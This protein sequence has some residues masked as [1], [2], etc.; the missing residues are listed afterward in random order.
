M[1]VF[2]RVCVSE[3]IVVLRAPV[4]SY[5]PFK[6]KQWQ[7][8]FLVLVLYPWRLSRTATPCP[9]FPE[10][11]VPLNALPVN[12]VTLPNCNQSVLKEHDSPRF[13][14]RV[15]PSQ[16]VW[17][18]HVSEIRLLSRAN[19][20]LFSVTSWLDWRFLRGWCMKALIQSRPKLSRN[21]KCWKTAVGC[22]RLSSSPDLTPPL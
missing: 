4:C 22:F 11:H 20:D 7:H 5:F 12:H 2:I 21:W 15:Q 3:V 13:V 9:N 1:C 17:E 19:K 18:S 16:E 8:S 10:A 14:L 6:K